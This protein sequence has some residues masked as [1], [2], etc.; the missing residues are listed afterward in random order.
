MVDYLA[1]LLPQ[2]TVF[3]VANTSGNARI[4]NVNGTLVE[5]TYHQHSDREEKIY[6][7]LDAPDSSGNYH[8][9]RQKH[10][11]QTGTW[12][13]KGARFTYWRETPDSALWVHGIPGCGKTI[14]CSIAID[15]IH[16]RNAGNPSIGCAYFFFDSRNAQ[17][18]LS[19]HH[20]L[21]R[22][23]IMQLSEQR[24]VIPAPLATIYGHGNRQASVDELQL[25]LQLIIDSFER[26]YIVIDALDE[27]ADRANVISWIKRLTRRKVGKVHVL[28]SSRPETDIEE[29]F[30]YLGTLIRVPLAGHAAENDIK[31]YLNA[32]LSKMTKWDAQTRSR[33][34]EVLL[35]G[36]GGI[37]RTVEAQLRSLPKDL[38]GIYEKILA[39]SKNPHELRQFLLWL[40][41]SNRPLEVEELA[42]VIAIDSSAD[43]PSYAE[44]LRY[45]CPTNTLVVCSGFVV[46]FGGFVKLAHMSVKEYLISERIRGGA[47]SFF[48]INETLAHSMIT[49]TCLAYLIQLGSLPY[50]NEST[51]KSFPLAPYAAKSWMAHMR[52]GCPENAQTK[53]LMHRLFSLEGNI[54]NN[55]V[56]LEDA[57]TDWFDPDRSNHAKASTDIAPPLYY[58][59]S[60]GVEGVVQQLLK[61]GEDVDA[62]GGR[63]GN[64]LRAASYGGHLEIV[65][66]LL[67]K[68]ADVNLQGGELGNAL[69][70]ASY[71]GHYEIA[72]LLLEKGA[73]PNAK[74]GD[75][76][77]ALQAASY[78]GHVA[79]AE[80]LLARGADVNANGGRYGSSLQAASY[81]GHIT[82]VQCLLKNGADVN[83]TGGR[84]G[85]S[86]Q[87]ASAN[88]PSRRVQSLLNGMDLI[89]G[90]GRYRWYAASDPKPS[91]IVHIVQ[92]QSQ[93]GEDTIVRILL[94]HGADPNATGGKYNNALQAASYHGRSIIVGLLLEKGAD[95]NAKGGGRG[96]ALQAACYEGHHE[97]VQLLL[98]NGANVNAPGGRYG[99][100]LTAASSRNHVGISRLL[101]DRGAKVH[102]RCDVRGTACA[103]SLS[104]GSDDGTIID[105]ETHV[106]PSRNGV[107]L[108]RRGSI[109]R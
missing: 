90:S 49:Q 86:L 46:R 8:A 36:A 34:R 22:S 61:S 17:I 3:N 73:H 93:G 42:D 68:G 35:R 89:P 39:R 84:Y 99:T 58:A 53:H 15:E 29:E 75:Y 107:S 12:F 62:R 54:L 91:A 85:S 37:P 71:R 45:F 7:W 50:I 4:T 105:S 51:L 70:A 88:W 103:T 83:A 76:D 5:N 101:L 104:S 10:H 28:F 108:K 97:V 100:A 66:L 33:V 38:E 92:A 79:V 40:A 96:T 14:L 27:C 59:S 95:P 48:G 1:P 109:K 52:L 69:Q 106:L 74:G 72:R 65:K 26:T 18:E 87:A 55:W 77:N 81:G 57:D 6:R 23:L 31:T 102:K 21:I 2:R 60:V 64:A 44:D 43:L 24:G 56:R 11:A 98:K 47:V 30:D 67:E 32:M 13:I 94:E 63:F 80:L 19:S 82:V 78:E 9:A 16:R 41:F 25:T 20:K